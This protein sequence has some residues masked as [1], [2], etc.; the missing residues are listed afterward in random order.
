MMK[1]REAF[2]EDFNEIWPIFHE[3]V[4]AGDTCA[5]PRDITREDAGTLWIDHPEKTFIFEEEGR[6]LGTY[7]IKK[8]QLGPGS[9][10]CNCSYMVSSQAR[11]DGLARLM[12]QHSQKIALEIGF[13]AMQ[14]NLVVSSNETAVNLWIKLGFD[15]VGTIPKAFDHPTR[16]YVDG[17]VMYKWLAD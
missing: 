4:S 16:G 12:C 2:N 8:N 7:Y 11:G 9:H 1:I 17:L 15:I 3:I 5:F 14:Y 13:K 10:V 6:I